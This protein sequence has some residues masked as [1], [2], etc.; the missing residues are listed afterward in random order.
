M[1]PDTINREIDEDEI[2]IKEI[3]ATI[4]RYKISILIIALLFTLGA[5]VYAYMAPSI[6]QAK[7]YIEV[8]EEYV[9]RIL[10]RVPTTRLRGR[11]V[12]FRKV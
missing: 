6:Y 11:T 4:K 2:D 10:Q 5:A 7:A 8:Q 3:F 1:A 9:D 12:T